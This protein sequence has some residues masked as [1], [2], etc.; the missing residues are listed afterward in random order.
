MHL[1]IKYEEKNGGQVGSFRIVLVFM[2]DVFNL[3]SMM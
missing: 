3:D 2:T 1:V